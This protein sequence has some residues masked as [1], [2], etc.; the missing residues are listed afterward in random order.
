ME[1]TIWTVNDRE[2]FEAPGRSVLVFHDVYPE[3]K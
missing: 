1:K 2:Y 3:G